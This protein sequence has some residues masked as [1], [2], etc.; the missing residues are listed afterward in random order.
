MVVVAAVVI[1]E[2]V[3]V[4]AKAG[5]IANLITEVSKAVEDLR[6]V[7]TKLRNARILTWEI[8]ST[9]ISAPMLMEIRILESQQ[10]D[11]PHK[12]AGFQLAVPL[13]AATLLLCLRPLSTFLSP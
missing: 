1:R 12:T 6:A 4:I 10:V 9:E 13:L 8:A 11:R 7:T 5:I 2:A 3:A